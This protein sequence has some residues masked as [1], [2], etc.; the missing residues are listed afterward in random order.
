MEAEMGV[1]L[2]QLGESVTG[3][4][5]VPVAVEVSG[6]CEVPVDVKVAFYRI[7]QEALNN[8]AKHSGA[9]QV[10]VNME[11]PDSEVRLSIRDNGKGFIMENISPDSLG[12]GIM[13]E[14]A[15]NIGA[16]FSLESKLGEGTQVTVVWKPSA[17]E[18]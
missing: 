9:K 18:T 1:L 10:W 11:C 12:V 15:R 14:R 5:R 13:Q 3:R 2:H 17:P 6:D 4:A 16:S 7:A 8:A